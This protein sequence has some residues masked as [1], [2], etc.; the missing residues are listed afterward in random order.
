MGGGGG[1]GDIIKFQSRSQFQIF[2]T[3]HCVYKTYRTGF[4]FCRLGH[5][6][7]VGLGVFWVINLIAP[8][9]LSVMLSP[10]KPL[11][12]IQPNLVCVCVLLT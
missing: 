5:A 11:D 8:V 3:K 7:E 2:Y 1:G 6:L 12:E 10:H 4:S 9:R